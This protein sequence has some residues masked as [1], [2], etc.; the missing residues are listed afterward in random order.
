MNFKGQNQG[1][2]VKFTN[3]V[4]FSMNFITGTSITPLE[5]SSIHQSHFELRL[6]RYI[7]DLSKINT[8]N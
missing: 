2:R 5:H 7:D 6:P 1:Y 4:H 8:F 3:H